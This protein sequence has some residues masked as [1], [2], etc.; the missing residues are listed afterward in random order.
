[1][2][3]ESISIWQYSRLTIRVTEPWRERRSGSPKR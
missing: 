3:Y 2:S 1:M